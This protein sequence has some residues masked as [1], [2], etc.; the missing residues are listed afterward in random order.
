MRTFHQQSIVVR[1]NSTVIGEVLHRIIFSRLCTLI[2]VIFIHCDSFAVFSIVLERNQGIVSLLCVFSVDGQKH[3]FKGRD[4]NTV[5]LDFQVIQFLI[6]LLEEL[7]E[8]ASLFLW[9]HESDLACN[10]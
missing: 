2:L 10:F 4:G 6:K 7:L 9:D 1:H 5:T 3:L 8:H